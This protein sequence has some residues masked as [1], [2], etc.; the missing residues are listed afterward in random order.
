MPNFLALQTDNPAV[1]S[2]TILVTGLIVVFLVLIVLTAIIKGYGTAI[3]N[4]A[5]KGE[6]TKEEPAAAAHPSAPVAPAAQAV[7][8]V[9][10]GIP[11]EV[12]AAI[13]AAVYSLDGMS[14]SAIH[15]IRRAR[16]TS[17]SAWGMAGIMENTRPF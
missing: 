17:R 8:H 2:L 6:K 1:L 16:K 5:N 10:A 7:P 13:A 4:I 11:G 9:E 14:G 15:S 3:F 12:V